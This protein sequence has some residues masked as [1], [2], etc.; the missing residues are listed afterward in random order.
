MADVVAAAPVFVPPESTQPAFPDDASAVVE[1]PPAAG[2]DAL[3]SETADSAPAASGPQPSGRSEPQTGEPGPRQVSG[4]TRAPVPGQLVA[5]ATSGQ[6]ASAAASGQVASAAAPAAPA[7]GGATRASH[8]QVPRVEP[9]RRMISVPVERD[10]DELSLWDDYGVADAPEPARVDLDSNR[11][12]QVNQMIGAS[13]VPAAKALSVAVVLGVTALVLVLLVG[14][15]L[16]LDSLILNRADA[17]SAETSVSAEP[18]P[19][20]T[21]AAE[22]ATETEETQSPSPTPTPSAKVTPAMDAGAKECDSGVWAGSQTSCVLANEVAKQVDRAMTDS[23]TVE[24]FS[25][26]SNRNYRLECSASEGI[27]CVG[28]DGVEG[29]AVWI[30]AEPAA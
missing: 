26:S 23:V 24:A 18:A 8:P 15:L 30:V 4:S 20:E 19:E 28:L 7:K 11:R 6:V 22:P 5:A 13:A 25:S 2:Q 21:A 16:T 1:A 3:S 27:S 12:D 14:R 29:L 10:P 17:A 9:Y